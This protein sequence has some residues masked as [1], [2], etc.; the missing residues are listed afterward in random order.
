MPEVVMVGNTIMEL[1]RIHVQFCCWLTESI[2]GDE[3]GTYVESGWTTSPGPAR[4]C[5]GRFKLYTSS[6]RSSRSCIY[7]G[8]A[9]TAFITFRLSIVTARNCI[10]AELHIFRFTVGAESTT[11]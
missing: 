7:C 8:L 1:E 2:C 10:F 5:G 4:R 6:M 11:L 3:V 9:Y